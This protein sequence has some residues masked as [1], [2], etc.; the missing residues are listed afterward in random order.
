[1]LTGGR[2]KP[3]A[4]GLSEALLAKGLTIDLIGSD[5]LED[6]ELRSKPGVNFLN[7]RGSHRKDVSA[8]AKA[9]RIFKYYAGLIA[10]AAAAKPKI[11]HILWNN[12][13]ETFD[14]TVLML[15][16][17]LLGKKIVL[18]A[19]NINAGIR[20]E[21]DSFFNRLTL[22]FQ[23]GLASHMFVH[24]EKMKGELVASY[25]VQTSRVTVIP[26]GINNAVPH[27]AL[28]PAEAR[29]RLG[30][31]REERVLLFFGRITPYK[32]LE[33]LIDAF[34]RVRNKGINSRL[35]I[36]GY[37]DRCNEY[38]S[39]L[40]ESIQPELDA[41][42]IVLK[43]E[44]IPD[45]ETEV[46]FKAADAFVLPYREI[47]QSGVLFLGLSFGLPVLAADVGSM[48][49]DVVEGENGFSFRAEDSDDMARVF[50]L[51]FQSDLYRN[52]SDLRERIR[53]RAEELHSWDI[54]GRKTLD[55]YSKLANVDQ[56]SGKAGTES[57]ISH[58]AAD[59]GG[60]VCAQTGRHEVRDVSR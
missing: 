20:D 52:L 51:F 7:L 10:Y 39:N 1:M 15:Y 40:R 18:T 3:Y 46:Y 35:L 8:I 38:W 44:F 9:A 58:G 43:A 56:S 28:T 45:E 30:L 12:K 36:A 13:I 21:N 14:R 23:Y 53:Q 11:F 29:E 41:R 34:R 31:R 37:P 16:Y 50:Q 6:T 27:T 22:K 17:R 47:Y 19:H 2:D 24:T 26:F 49:H 4:L 59:D 25:G 55:V 48:K 57:T 60:P 54:V 32:G 42:D 5:D 33:F